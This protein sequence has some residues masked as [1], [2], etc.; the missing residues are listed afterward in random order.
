[1]G[2]RSTTKIY[3]EEEKLILAIYKQMDGYTDGW[4][5]ELKKFIKSG[6]FVNGIGSDEG[7]IFNGIGDFALLLVNHFKNGPGDIY[8]TNSDNSQEYN[9]II[10]PNMGSGYIVDSI[11]IECKEDASFNETIKNKR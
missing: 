8:A 4:G 3:D 7:T 11:R 10:K 6:K 5:T 1:M 9:Y 2:T